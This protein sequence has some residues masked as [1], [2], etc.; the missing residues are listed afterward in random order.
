MSLHSWDR[1]PTEPE[2]RRFAAIAKLRGDRQRRRVVVRSVVAILALVGT[3]VVSVLVIWAA[4]V[5][6]VALASF[7]TG[8]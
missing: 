4:I 6:V 2:R 7:V 1:E 5:G 8:R 3:A